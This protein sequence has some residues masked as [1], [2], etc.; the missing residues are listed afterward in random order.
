MTKFFFLEIKLNIFSIASTF[1]LFFLYVIIIPLFIGFW[2]D[3]LYINHL[4]II[5]TSILFSFSTEKFYQQDW[6]DGTLELYFL[7]S[8]ATKQIFL[9]K[10]LGNWVVKASGILCS[11]PILAL[12][13]HFE[14][15]FYVTITFFLGSFIFM[16]I[17][18]LHSCLAIGVEHSS[19][20]NSLQYLTTLPTFLP[21][22]MLCTSIQNFEELHL[23][24]LIGYFILFFLI[25]IYLV[26]LTLLNVL[27]K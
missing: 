24:F 14:P 17:S 2:P 13:Y 8:L 23:F 4:G 3:L 26:S 1:S 21:L 12:F 6:Q 27:S 16:L 9:S 18:S 22:I 19:D 15:S 20:W 5:W 10:L 11:Y 7:S 25:Y